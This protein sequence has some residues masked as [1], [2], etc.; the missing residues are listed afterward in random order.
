MMKT[1]T[2]PWTMFLYSLK[3][4][5]PKVKY[6]HRLATFLAFAGLPSDIPEEEQARLFA[7]KVA[8]DMNWVFDVILK[9]VMYHLERMNRGRNSSGHGLAGI[10]ISVL[11]A[12]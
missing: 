1:Q 8:S 6:S 5:V 12:V 4:P 9:F 7:S 3:S 2:D 11:F 10:F